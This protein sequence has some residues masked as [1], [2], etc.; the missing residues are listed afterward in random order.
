MMAAQAESH[1][2]EIEVMVEAM[3]R[4]QEGLEAEKEALAAAS[5]GKG[6]RMPSTPVRTAR[7]TATRH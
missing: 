1:E 5:A 3:R 4:Q 6:W 2:R 7:A